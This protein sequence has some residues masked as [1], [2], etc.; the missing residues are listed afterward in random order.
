MEHDTERDNVQ[1]V[2]LMGNWMGRQGILLD[3]AIRSSSG[4]S[5]G[6]LWIHRSTRRDNF[7]INLM[8]MSIESGLLVSFFF[9]RSERKIA[10]LRNTRKC[11]A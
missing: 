11:L 4:N 2:E 1:D 5:C 8:I 3:E 6:N 7:C 10:P 9:V